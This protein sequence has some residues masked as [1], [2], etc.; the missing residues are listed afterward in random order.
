LRAA[1]LRTAI[2]AGLGLEAGQVT[3]HY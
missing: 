1:A 2:E 3:V